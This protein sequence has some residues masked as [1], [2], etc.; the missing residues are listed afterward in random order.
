MIFFTQCGDCKNMIMISS[1]PEGEPFGKCK[2]FPEGIPYD[3]LHSKF[4]HN[5]P[6]PGDNGIQFEGTQGQKRAKFFTS[7]AYKGLIDE[8]PKV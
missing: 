7:P 1:S 3:L 5:K 6:Y 2:A 4:E 8:N